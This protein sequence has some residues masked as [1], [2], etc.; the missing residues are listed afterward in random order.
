MLRDFAKNK[1]DRECGNKTQR[2]HIFGFNYTLSKL[3]VDNGL[4]G[5]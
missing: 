2:L 1:M 3:I 5:L 4:E